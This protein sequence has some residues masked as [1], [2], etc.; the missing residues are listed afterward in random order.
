MEERSE[1]GL[2]IFLCGK[3]H[4]LMNSMTFLEDYAVLRIED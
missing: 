1:R 3:T 2:I 4:R